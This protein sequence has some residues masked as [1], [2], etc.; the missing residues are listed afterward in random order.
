[1]TATWKEGLHNYTHKKGFRTT[2]TKI[3][4]L[5]DPQGETTKPIKFK[6]S[7]EA[8]NAG[9]TFTGEIFDGIKLNP[10]FDISDLGIIRNCSAYCVSTEDE[11][12]TRIVMLTLKGIEFIKSL[13]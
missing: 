9:E 4:N 13:Y 2:D 3:I 11:F 10:V 6:F 7:Y 12:K 5:S 1:M 8:Y